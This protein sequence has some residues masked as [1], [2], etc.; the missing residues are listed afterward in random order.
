M[1]YVVHLGVTSP[2]PAKQCQTGKQ[3]D[4]LI[5]SDSKRLSTPICIQPHLYLFL[6][7]LYISKPG[8]SCCCHGRDII[9]TQAHPPTNC[10]QICR[11]D[12]HLHNGKEVIGTNDIGPEP[13]PLFRSIPFKCIF[14]CHEAARSSS[15]FRRFFFLGRRFSR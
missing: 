13:W 9:N 12:I 7:G 2:Q 8:N 11:R 4:F 15:G 10:Y 3:Y 14:T 5:L 6:V 1:S